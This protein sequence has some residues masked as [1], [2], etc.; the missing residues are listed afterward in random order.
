MERPLYDKGYEECLQ[1]ILEENPSLENITRKYDVI[2]QE[3][4]K[5][6]IGKEEDK[7]CNGFLKGLR[8]NLGIEK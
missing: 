4:I 2:E 8:I 3:R 6:L 7:Y 1:W 5:M